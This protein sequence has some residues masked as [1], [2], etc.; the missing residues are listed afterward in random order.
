[1]AVNQWKLVDIYIDIA[2]KKS[3]APRKDYTRMVDDCKKN[4]VDI[5]ITKA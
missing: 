2:Y 4:K 5:V 1:V 3:K